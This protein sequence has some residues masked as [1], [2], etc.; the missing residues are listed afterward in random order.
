MSK[1]FLIGNRPRAVSS[2]S[3]WGC[4]WP[5]EARLARVSRPERRAKRAVTPDRLASGSAS[6]QQEK[7]CIFKP[8]WCKKSNTKI[9]ISMHYSDWKCKA[10]N[11]KLKILPYCYETY[12]IWHITQLILNSTFKSVRLGSRGRSP[13]KIFAFLSLFDARRAIQKLKLQCIIVIEN[14]NFYDG[15]ML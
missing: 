3:V 6:P 8:F 2:F 12:V 10:E 14:V 5:S 13:R 1:W 7:F 4:T 15:S 11:A 9:E